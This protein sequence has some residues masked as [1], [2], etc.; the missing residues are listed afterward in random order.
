MD[1]IFKLSSILTLLLL[2]V[3]SPVSFATTT[4]PGANT[5]TVYQTTPSE[6]INDTAITSE[7]KAKYLAD[8]DIHSLAI[9]VSTDKGV[10]Y[11]K[12]TVDNNQ[13][14][15]KAVKIAREVSGVKMVKD[16]LVVKKVS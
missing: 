6:F 13:Q 5:G 12:G 15:Q 10:V 7:I 3:I 8:S 4:T 14:K 2:F 11:L 9:S 1:K 16:D